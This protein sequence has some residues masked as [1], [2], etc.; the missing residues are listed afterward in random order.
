MTESMR[1]LVY[2][3]EN[4]PWDDSRGL[5]LADIPKVTLDEKSDYHD[6]SRVLI[7]PKFVGF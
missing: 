1:A 5:R 4:D 6:R 7:K 2:D 3:R